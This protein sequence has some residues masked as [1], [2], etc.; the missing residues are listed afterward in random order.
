MNI[1][2]STL[3]AL[4]LSA[5]LTILPSLSHAGSAEA[6]KGC[7]AE[8]RDDARLAPYAD[9]R[10]R[11]KKFSRS[12]PNKQ[13]DFKVTGVDGSGEKISWR[14]TCVASMSGKVQSLE[15]LQTEGNSSLQV[16]ES[17]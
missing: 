13:I 8:L 15:L 6:L 10:A 5:C 11:A 4:S 7:E 12:G 2:N 3:T 9:T 16:A 14:A 17:E 1:L